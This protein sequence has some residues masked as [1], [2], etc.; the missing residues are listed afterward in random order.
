MIEE[1]KESMINKRY[2]KY[3]LYF[4]LIIITVILAQYFISRKIDD[5][6][7]AKLDYFDKP[8][9]DYRVYYKE[10]QYFDEKYITKDNTYVSNLI[11]YIDVDFSYYLSYS[12]KLQASSNYSIIANIVAKTA[13]SG[14]VIWDTYKKELLEVKNITIE[15]GKDYNINETV[16]IDYN[17]FNEF[18]MEFKNSNQ[19]PVKAYLKVSLNISNSASHKN[20]KDIASTN[21]LE[22]QIP[23]NEV[24]FKITE[25]ANSKKD[26]YMTTKSRKKDKI[27][28]MITG[29][30][31]W[32]IAITLG[33]LL[34]STYHK[35]FQK[36]S[37]YKRKLRKIL[38]TY[39]SIIVNVEKFP[40]V[41]DL[42]VV[43]V[44]S[45]E[46]LVDAQNEVRLPINFKENKRKN[47]ARFVLIRNNLAWVYVLKEGDVVEK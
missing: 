2:I 44:T 29:S 22:V 32:L 20:F 46:E 8:S 9:I 16:R 24:S 4:I 17:E 33:V 14:E 43:F 39:D 47:M 23:L 36:Q 42:S 19:M 27:R 25:S 7:L 26:V 45:F 28:F 5:D 10:N 21:V 11:D 31:L 18:F 12:D 1:K 40:F 38:S 3:S 41:G 15:D 34:A 35:D 30:I 37:I 6:V 13:S